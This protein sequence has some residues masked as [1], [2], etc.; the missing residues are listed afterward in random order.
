[1]RFAQIRGFKRRVQLFCAALLI[2]FVIRYLNSQWEQVRQT[3][4]VIDWGLL[5]VAQFGMTLGL[6]MLPW[7]SWLALKYLGHVRPAA[8]V[9]RIFFISNLAKYLPGSV[10]ALPGRAFLYQRSGVPAG[11]SIA[12]VFW[13]VLLMIM[14]T[15]ALALLSIPLIAHYVDARVLAVGILLGVIGTIG[16]G[17]LLH[18]PAFRRWLPAA[19]QVRFFRPD[20]GQMA[21]SVSQIAK[22]ILAYLLSWSVIGLSFA[23]MMAS[24]SPNLSV[25]RWAE[26]AG[27]YCGTWLIGFLAFFAPGGIGVRDVL[28]ALGL[29]VFLGDPLPLV[30]A[31]I[32]R[33][34]WTLAEISGVIL[35]LSY[36]HLFSPPQKAPILS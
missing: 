8:E 16:G 5:A 31:V 11:K 30:A 18:S 24:L 14:T 15:S 6:G 3:P 25:L 7:G 35:T 19:I 36:K 32:A 27:L 23:A 12:A 20:I 28:I 33:I 34:M 13:E 2:F 17:F 9:W 10:W 21:L 22:M 29:S 4:V 1:M 26:L